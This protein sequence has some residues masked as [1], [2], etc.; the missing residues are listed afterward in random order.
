[1][2]S[3]LRQVL[4]SEVLNRLYKST[5]EPLFTYC[6]SI[7]C[8]SEKVYTSRLVILQKAAARIISNEYRFA[9]S[10]PLFE[11]LNW[12]SIESIWER[13]S[14][15]L[16]HQWVNKSVPTMLHGIITRKPLKHSRQCRK[17]DEFSA[18]SNTAKLGFYQKSIFGD[19]V[20]SYNLLEKSVRELPITQ[21]YKFV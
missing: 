9:P 7:W 11:T 20:E 15:I 19:G 12:K 3:R 4:P 14:R 10:K 18:A 16:V 8:F 1:M 6:S 21:F 17:I 13:R 2:L 5:I